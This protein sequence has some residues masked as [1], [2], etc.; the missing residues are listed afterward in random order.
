MKSPLLSKLFTILIVLSL[1]LSACGPRTSI[2][3]SALQRVAAPNVGADELHGLTEANNAFALDLY[4][5]LR[6][7][8]G[9]LIYSPYSISLALA[10]TYAGA[11]GETESQMAQTLHFLPQDKL[12]AALNELDQ[13]LAKRGQAQ[14]KDQ[15]PLQLNIANSIWAEQTFPFLKDYLDVIAQN[16]GAGIQLADFINGHEA[17][18][19]EINGWVSNKTNDKIKDL[20]PAGVLDATTR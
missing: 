19:K 14:S 6:S 7:R 12:H 2:A 1:S 13:E 9:N 11:R 16:Y 4:Q 5:S 20:I 18:R 10:M 17:V 8:D 3:K 15:K